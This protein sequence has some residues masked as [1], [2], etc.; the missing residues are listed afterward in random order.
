MSLAAAAEPPKRPVI[1]GK[2]LYSHLTEGTWQIW[3]KELATDQETQ[4]TSIPGDKRRPQWGGNGQVA[5]CTTNYACFE[6]TVGSQAHELRFHELWPVRDL[7]RSPDGKRLVFSKFRTDVPDQA[8]LWVANGDESSPH[9]ITHEP[10]IQQQP[11]WSPDDR[12]IAYSGGQGPNSYEIYAVKADGTGRTQLT[13]NQANDFLPAWSPDGKQ[14]AYASNAS[15]DD[16]IWVMDA[17]GS[18][19]TQLTHSPGLDTNPTWS[20]DGRS[21]AF[22]TNRTGEMEIWVM[23]ADGSEQQLL[24]KAE[25]GVCDPAWR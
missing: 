3:Q 4:V 23:N 10:G 17:D 25:G 18:H 1:Q 11:A 7:M 5:Y 21:I 8:N 16:E 15:G 19:Q 20:L 14:I 12:T 13:K 22:A 6:N 2:L 9:M 24:L